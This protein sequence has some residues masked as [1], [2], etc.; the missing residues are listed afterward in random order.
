MDE[1]AN[2]GMAI[3]LISS[4]VPEVLGVCDRIV[5]MCRGRITGEY[6]NENIGQDVLLKS[7]SGTEK[8]R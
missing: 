5:A 1:L 4:E 6:V 3:L 7:A 2:K 8:G